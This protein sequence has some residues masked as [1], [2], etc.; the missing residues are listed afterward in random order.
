MD[1]LTPSE[2]LIRPSLSASEKFME[3]VVMDAFFSHVNSQEDE[4]CTRQESWCDVLM[5]ER[6][7]DEYGDQR[8]D[9]EEHPDFTGLNMFDP[10][11][12]E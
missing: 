12:I 1:K 4:K 9:I 6:D 8:I 7:C 2:S 3:R 10:E 5:E 11:I